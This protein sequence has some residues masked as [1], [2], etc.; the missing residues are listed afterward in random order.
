MGDKL[1]FPKLKLLDTSELEENVG[2]L[3]DLL[4]KANNLGEGGKFWEQNTGCA[5]VKE[6]RVEMHLRWCHSEFVRG[7]DD[8]EQHKQCARGEGEDYLMGY[9]ESYAW[10]EMQ[11]HDPDEIPEDMG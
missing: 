10:G 6:W 1:K 9:N 3:T 8:A 2:L 5:D 11:G 7:W 4:E